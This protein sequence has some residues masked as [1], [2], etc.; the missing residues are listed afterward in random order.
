MII[1]SYGGEVV[2][3]PRADGIRGALASAAREANR[4]G[5]FSPLQFSN[6]DNPGAHRYRTAQEIIAQ[7]PGG[8]V[9]AVVSGVGTGGTLVGLCQ[10]F[11][12]FGCAVAPFAARP[13]NGTAL[14]GAECCSFSGRIPGVVDGL[15][16]IYEAFRTESSALV[17]LDISD[18]EALDVARAL[19]RKGFPVGPSSGLNF[20]AAM[21]AADRLGP[22]AHIVTVFPDRM[23]RYFSTELF[24]KPDDDMM[25]DKAESEHRP[26][27]RHPAHYVADS[28]FSYLEHDDFVM[29]GIIR[30]RAADTDDA[31][32]R[33]DQALLPAPIE[34]EGAK[35]FA[36]G[37][38]GPGKRGHSPEEGHRAGRLG[39]I[40]DGQSRGG[41]AVLG[42]H[43][44]RAAGGGGDHQEGCAQ[45]PGYQA[46]GLDDAL[47]DRL[48]PAGPRHAV[49]LRRSVARVRCAGPVRDRPGPG[50]AGAKLGKQQGLGLA[51][52]PA[53]HGDGFDG[54]LTDRRLAREH[55]GIGAVEHGVEYVARLG[56][57]RPAARFHAVEHLG[58][59]DHRHPRAMAGVD[60]LFLDGRHPNHVQLDTQVAARDH[61]GV[62]LGDD[63]VEIGEGLRLLDLGDDPGAAAATLELAAQ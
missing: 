47:G 19:I 28:L 35:L 18:D 12:D 30:P 59:R 25:S 58:G 45:A 56:T 48:D 11:A 15:S 9:D 60:D 2:F 46:G 16:A 42:E 5:G 44:G 61:H 17:E 51:G 6:P 20:R 52:D 31:V 14:D 8:C 53:H 39:V 4:R 21:M 54:V 50:C 57:G 34:D 41:V 26:V 29:G 38:V 7:I 43:Q 32:A 24:G 36:V 49:I 3:S 33:C 37:E 1:E 40:G 55:H 62:G 63:R 22:E 13:V 27:P 10:G 23:E